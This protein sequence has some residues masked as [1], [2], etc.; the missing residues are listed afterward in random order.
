MWIYS[1]K[2]T[3][4]PV[5][6]SSGPAEQRPGPGGEDQKPTFARDPARSRPAQRPAAAARPFGRRDAALLAAGASLLALALLFYHSLAGGTLLRANPYDSYLLQAQNWLK[7][8]TWIQNGT[9]Y[10]WLELAVYQGRYYLSFPPVPSLFALPLAAAELSVGN[11]LQAGYALLLFAGVY[12]CFWQQGGAPEH[13]FFWAAF[14]CLGSGAFWLSCSG[15][16]WFAAQLLNLCLCVWGILFWL[17]GQYPGAF[18][19][20]ALAVGCRPFSAVLALGLYLPAAAG[21]IRA[22]RIGRLAVCSLPPLLTAAALAAYNLARFGNPLEFGHSYLPEFV[23]AEQGQFS[24]SYFAQNAAKL[25]R[26]VTLNAALDLEFPLFD[27]F[28]F[29]VA[30]PLFLYWGVML[31]RAAHKKQ[32]R[33]ADALLLG[34]FALGFCL[35]CLHRTMGGWQFGARYTLDLLCW[36]LLFFLANS[37]RA[38]PGLFGRWLAAAGALFNLYGAVYMLQH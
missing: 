22:K 29:F 35:L 26:P 20:L 28:L 12:L 32:F 31:L 16:V 1:K 19:L 36:P 15:G 5:G 6:L 2:P 25:L 37:R 38:A 13:C 18:F 10:P 7:G 8:R 34:G 24:L 33:S 14:V 30:N 23:R 4:P 11:L 3:G 9:Q 21:L 17:R 27:G